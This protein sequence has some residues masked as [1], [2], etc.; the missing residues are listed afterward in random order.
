MR[1]QLHASEE[2]PALP[3]KQEAGSSTEPILSLSRRDK[4]VNSAG[5]QTRFLCQQVHSLVTVPTT[6]SE[7]QLLLILTY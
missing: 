3:D 6:P 7:K 1:V 4:S 5:N 2:A